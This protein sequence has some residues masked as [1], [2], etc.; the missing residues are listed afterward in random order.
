MYDLNMNLIEL[1]DG[2]KPLDIFISSI[3]KNRMWDQVE[4]RSGNVDYGYRY[5]SREIE[6]KILL[7]A[8]DTQDYRLL[9]DSVYETF[10][11]DFFVS[12]TYQ[13]GKKY[14]VS[15][16]DPYIPERLRGNQR[17]AEVSIICHQ[18]ELPFAESIGT[19]MDIHN[20][21]INYNDELWGYGMGLIYNEESH[22]YVHNSNNFKIFNAGN[23]DEHHPY[24]QKLKITITGASAG[25]ELKNT[26]TGDV[27]KLIEQP[28]GTI[29][30]DGPLVTDNGLRALHKT[31]KQFISLVPGWN[32]FTQ[33][34]NATVSFDF[35]FYYK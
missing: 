15:V 1:P 35:P 34:Q 23:I 32:E 19:S 3:R 26:S 30:L 31:N 17:F 18:L 16:D 4:G 20:N 14:L 27:F 11:G 21:G 33:N 25:Y 28:N 13:P 7:I 8:T 24:E 6:L 22:V 2:V 9:R 12:E 10:S 5:G 29:L